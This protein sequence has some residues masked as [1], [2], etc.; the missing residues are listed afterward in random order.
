MRETR[1]DGTPTLWVLSTNK[2]YRILAIMWIIMGFVYV[3][4]GI[5]YFFLIPSFL[6]FPYLTFTSSLIIIGF[7]LYFVIGAILQLYDSQS[8]HNDPFPE[9]SSCKMHSDQPAYDW[10]AICGVLSCPQELV[11][12]QQ[13]FWGISLSMF[14]FDGVACQDCA[15]RR[16]KRY[17]MISIILILPTF[18]LLI[19][20]SVSLIMAGPVYLAAILGF[21]FGIFVFGLVCLTAWLWWKVWQIVT[22]P[23]AQQPKLMIPIKTR[24]ARRETV[25]A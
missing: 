22:T 10:C 14:G 8:I 15:Q 7:G 13:K 17:Y 9:D 12:I 6:L 11:R 21:I 2:P 20:L 24:L 23:L 19:F 18:L 3:I 5:Q 25:E 4:I 16:V 1:S